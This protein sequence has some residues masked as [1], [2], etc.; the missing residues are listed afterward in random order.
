MQA[1]AKKE[2]NF[3]KRISKFE[4]KLPFLDVANARVSKLPM[5]GEKF[6]YK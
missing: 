1:Q 6:D 5:I 2:P 4:T 3:E